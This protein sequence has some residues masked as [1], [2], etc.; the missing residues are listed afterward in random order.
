MPQCS[1]KLVERANGI[2]FQALIESL[3]QIIAPS[4]LVVYPLPANGEKLILLE[5]RQLR[6]TVHNVVAHQKRRIDFGVA[7]PARMQIEHELAKRALKPRKPGTQHDKARAGELGRGCKIHLPERFADIEMLF[8]C[9]VEVSLGSEMVPLDIVARVLAVRYIFARHVRKLGQRVIELLR[10]LLLCSFERRNLGLQAANFRKQSLRSRFLVAL[11]G[12]A[13]LLRCQIAPGLRGLGGP[14]CRAA[15][16]VQGDE[17]ACFGGQTTPGK[18]MIEFLR[19]LAD[20]SDV[21]HASVP[22]SG[23]VVHANAKH[24]RPPLRR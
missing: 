7:V 5:F 15:A 3:R 9:K 6:G 11:L 24:Q 13:N 21:V 19:V 20:P 23:A 17:P 14:N 12:G 1:N 18:R 8:W 4:Q 22:C 10:G 16:F 2:F